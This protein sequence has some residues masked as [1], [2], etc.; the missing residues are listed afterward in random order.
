M[1][2]R[3]YDDIIDPIDVHSLIA[4]TACSNKAFGVCSKVSSKLKPLNH[5]CLFEYP[6]L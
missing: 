1:Q 4:L 3:D 2:L 6:S 5:T